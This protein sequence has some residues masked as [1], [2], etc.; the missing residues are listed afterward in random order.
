MAMFQ[1][2]LILSLVYGI[3]RI[4]PSYDPV[5]ESIYRIKFQGTHCWNV[6]IYRMQQLKEFDNLSVR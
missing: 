5:N 4:L 6:L 1:L 3:D 2:F